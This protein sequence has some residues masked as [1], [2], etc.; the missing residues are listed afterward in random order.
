MVSPKKQ[1]NR[2]FILQEII[3]ENCPDLIEQEGKIDIKRVHRTPST[4][5]PQKTTPR[6]VIAKFKSFRAKEKI[7]QESKKRQFRYQGAPIRI[8]QDLAVSTLKDRKA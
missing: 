5:T 3:Q 4:L 1:T 6:N 8:T 2:N 7:L